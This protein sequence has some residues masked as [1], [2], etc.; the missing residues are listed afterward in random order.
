LSATVTVQALPA[1]PVN[2]I[3][4]LI[5]TRMDNASVTVGGNAV[6]PGQVVPLQAG[7]VEATMIVRRLDPAQGAHVGFTVTDVC[8]DWPSFVGGGPG[9]F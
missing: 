8:G 4:R 6:T 1:T 2:S 5:V 3:Q 7:S 9:S